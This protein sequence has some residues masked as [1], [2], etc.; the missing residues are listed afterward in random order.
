MAH[1]GGRMGVLLKKARRIVRGRVWFFTVKD[2][3]GAKM[4]W[5][6]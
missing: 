5:L 4:Q 1:R 6:K 3:K 2:E